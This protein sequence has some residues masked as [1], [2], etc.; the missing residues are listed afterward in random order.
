MF[1]RSTFPA[2]HMSGL[3]PEEIKAL[4]ALCNAWNHFNDLS[5]HGVA[6]QREYMDAIHRCQQI[7]ALRV[8][9]RIDPDIWRNPKDGC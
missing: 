3:T 1:T 8:A 7:I 9:R 2:Y 4:D 5:D 6:D